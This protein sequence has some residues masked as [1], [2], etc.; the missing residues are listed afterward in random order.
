M[1]TSEFGEDQK[2]AFDLA[3]TIALPS[4]FPAFGRL[5]VVRFTRAKS[6]TTQTPA[7]G[8]KAENKAYYVLK[9]VQS[10][11]EKLI[12]T[13]FVSRDD[14]R[15]FRVYGESDYLADPLASGIHDGDA[16]RDEIDK[17]DWSSV[18]KD[19]RGSHEVE[20]YPAAVLYVPEAAQVL[21]RLEFGLPAVLSVENALYTIPTGLTGQTGSTSPA[22]PYPF[23]PREDSCRGSGGGPP[24]GSWQFRPGDFSCRGTGPG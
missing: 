17:L 24:H 3:G 23:F 21:V 9:L 12:I 19:E 8:K 2:Q 22:G 15:A 20:L 11:S 13:R 6:T 4:P 5:F 10:V 1:P 16:L 18:G 7:Q 14:V